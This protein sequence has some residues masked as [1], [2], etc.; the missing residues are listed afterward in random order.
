MEPI[1]KPGKDG[2]KP[3]NY[4]PVNLLSAYR[5]LSSLIILKRII[6]KI[7]ASML[8]SQYAYRTGKSTGDIVLA[9]KYLP[10][11]SSTKKMQQVCAWRDMCK[12]FDTVD[13]K[14]LID[15]LRR[16]GIEE[17]NVTIIKSIKSLLSQTTL[18]AKNGKTIGEPFDTNRGVPHGD[19]LSHRLFTLY[20]YEALREIDLEIATQA[21]KRQ[22][23]QIQGHDNA[24]KVTDTQ[25]LGI[26][27]RCRF[28]LW[29]SWKSTGN[30]P[31]CHKKFNLQVNQS[32]TEYTIYHKDTD[33][34]KTKK[35]GT[36]L[37]E[38]AEYQRRKQLATMA[39]LK[40]RKIWKNRYISLR[41]KM[42][43]YIVYVRSILLYNSST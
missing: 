31:K 26:C 35:L 7:E 22:D 32:M 19:G 12:A 24:K 23:P 9:H 5:K 16:R 17:E 6:P 10:A 27:R 29:Q 25:A 42:T 39:L 2:T 43:I 11:G 4:M 3:D 34:I 41:D 20:L 13:R 18:R 40:Y 28:H 33:L 8:P 15:I 37:D 36:K 1:L 38:C 14:R 30:C 21:P